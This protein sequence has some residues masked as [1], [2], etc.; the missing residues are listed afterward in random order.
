MFVIFDDHMNGNSV[1]LNVDL[2]RQV[3]PNP[4]NAKGSTVLEFG[5]GKR[6]VVAGP[7][8]FVMDVIAKAQTSV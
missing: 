8:K 4:D 2:I 5:D 7:F 3:Y 6:V 1:A